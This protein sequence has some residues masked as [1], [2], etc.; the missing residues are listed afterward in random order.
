MNVGVTD[1][2]SNTKT[3]RAYRREAYSKGFRSKFELDVYKW[4]N[5]YNLDVIYEPCKIQ[6]TVPEKQHSYTPDFQPKSI[7]TV[8]FEAKG[9]FSQADRKK[10]LYVIKSNPQVT[11]KIIFQNSQM[12][13]SKRSNTTYADWCDKNNIEWCDWKDK[14][15]LKRWCKT[16]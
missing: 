3:K 13:I 8:F 11:F 4:F 2:L 15:K 1:L 10:M 16:K 9:Y 6:Y 14:S 7:G 12:K 5:E